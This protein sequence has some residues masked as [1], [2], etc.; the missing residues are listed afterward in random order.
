[1]NLTIEQIT[2]IN[3]V[4]L[5]IFR[6]FVNVCKK[7]NLKY[8]LVHGSLLGA[9][10]YKGFFPGDDDI[11]VLMP[12]N[13]YEKLVNL[14]PKYISRNYFIQSC[15]SEKEYPLA[16]V[17][18]R[19]SRTTYIQE[20]IKDLKINHGV[21]I[22]IFPLDFSPHF[23]KIKSFLFSKCIAVLNLRISALIKQKYKKKRTR[24][25]LFFSKLMFP[26]VKIAMLLREKMFASVS[27][28][29]F[30]SVYGGK[31][32]ERQMPV[33]WFG[34]GCL[35]D[36]EGINVVAPSKYKD[37]L[38]HIYGDFE[39]YSPV[40]KLMVGPNLVKMNACI[41]DLDKSYTEYL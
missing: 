33:S 11:D 9:L 40:E 18:I 14:G 37:Y 12:R 16:M 21:Y 22:D 32:V 1:M 29:N 4:Q 10:R 25:I 15:K 13:D 5:E 23:G 2:E 19:D 27:A 26:S 3:K 39:N 30:Y 41:V 8:Y 35:M 28:T 34:D 38:R 17:K 6:D 24:L 31:S 36:F 20:N 7:I